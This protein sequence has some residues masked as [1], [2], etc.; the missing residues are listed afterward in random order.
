MYKG[1]L[2]NTC[3]YDMPIGKIGIDISFDKICAI[4]ICDD[5]CPKQGEETA[6]HRLAYKQLSEYFCGLRRK[7]ELPL[8][9]LGTDLQKKVWSDLLDIHHGTTAGYGQ[10]AKAIGKPGASRAV[11]RANHCN[12]LLI[13]V[14]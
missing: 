9:A 13:A 12:P 11:G 4:F 8:E 7:F 10:I 6:L 14:P 1:K 2:Q 3:Y 5:A